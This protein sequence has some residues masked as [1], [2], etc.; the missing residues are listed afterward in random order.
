MT[1]MVVF[2]FL[3]VMAYINLGRGKTLF[4]LGMPYEVED[5]MVM[6]LCVI[7]IAR[8][9]W[10]LIKIEHKNELRPLPKP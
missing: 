1:M 2:S 6:L 9:L 3:F 8:L 5:T 10:S 7:A 4:G